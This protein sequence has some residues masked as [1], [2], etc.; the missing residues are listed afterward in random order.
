M[1][2]NAHQFP[3]FVA[4]MARSKHRFYPVPLIYIHNLNST[5]EQGIIIP[6]RFPL[7]PHI[8]K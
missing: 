7:A 4:E 8:L 5:E 3:I 6:I 1:S 2:N